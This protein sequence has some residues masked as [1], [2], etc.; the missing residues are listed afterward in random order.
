MPACSTGRSRHRPTRGHAAAVAGPARRLAGW[1]ATT[2]EGTVVGGAVNGRGRVVR[3]AGE[4]LRRVQ[5]G[6]VRQYALGIAGGAVLLL[7]WILLRAG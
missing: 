7:A 6:Y 4:R 3:A 1:L 2:E 5:S